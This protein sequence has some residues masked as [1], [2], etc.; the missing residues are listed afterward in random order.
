[1][2]I[3]D[4]TYLKAKYKVK[5]TTE[6]CRPMKDSKVSDASQELGSQISFTKMALYSL[7]Q[8]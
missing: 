1:M 7:G 3:S 6:K 5:S 2:G 8:I 4:D